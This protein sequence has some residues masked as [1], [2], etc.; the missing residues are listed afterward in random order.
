MAAFENTL[1]GLHGFLRSQQPTNMIAP[2]T[3]LVNSAP[4]PAPRR[5]PRPAGGVGLLQGLTGN[6]LG[7]SGGF[8]SAAVPTEARTPALD[9]FGYAAPS[10]GRINWAGF[11]ASPFKANIDEAIGRFGQNA[12]RNLFGASGLGGLFGAQGSALARSGLMSSSAQE[13]LAQRLGDD[14]T[15]S[16]GDFTTQA[17]GQG[18]RD[19]GTFETSDLGRISAENLANASRA[20]E[21][22]RQNQNVAS[23]ERYGDLERAAKIALA[24]AGREQEGIG[25]QVRTRAGLFDTLFNEQARERERRA[26]IASLPLDLLQRIM[27][28]GGQVSSGSNRGANP[29][30][31]NLFGGFGSRA[32]EALGGAVFG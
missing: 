19:Y 21:I 11:G 28:Q 6:L 12:R 25:R 13:R 9:P 7:G 26:G 29:F 18:I 30:L 14:L 17:I 1:A 32:G 15:R 16:V 27:S 23:M 8:A 10:A 2:P 4:R 31:S 20:A 22:A 5:V 24:N 3:R